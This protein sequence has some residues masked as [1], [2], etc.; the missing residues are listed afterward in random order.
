MDFS[1]LALRQF[2]RGMTL[3]AG[4]GRLTCATYSV[5][6][7]AIF[8]AFGRDWTEKHVGRSGIECD[9]FKADKEDHEAMVRYM[10]RA[11]EL[12]ELIYNLHRVSG[13][14]ER[15]ES[16]RT[17]EKT[18]IESGIAELIAGKFFKIVNVMFQYVVT[19]TEP[20]QDTPKNPDIEY[21]TGLTRFESCEVKGN[22]QSTDLNERSIYNTLKG[23]KGQLPKGKA[24][25][26]LLRVPENW[27]AD[28]AAGISV[29][30]A[31]VDRFIEREKTTRVSSVFVFASE[32]RFPMPGKTAH[33]FRV[34]EFRNRHCDM[35]SGITIP[36]LAYGVPNWRCLQDV[37]EGELAFMS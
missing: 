19:K 6:C 1:E 5:A 7:C 26:I 23:A 8:Q 27:L 13:F 31:A 4:P 20:G 33:I 25:V 15:I 37:T 14:D 12:G 17:D 35:A 32:T 29:I 22:L 9:Y 16:I 30:Q 21:V 36:N 2:L 11:T 18:G 28:M 24:G 3:S 34:K 10:S